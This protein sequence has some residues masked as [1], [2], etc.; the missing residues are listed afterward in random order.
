MAE[1]AKEVK[2]SL[3]GNL[4]YTEGQAHDAER[5]SKFLW[6]LG[7]LMREYGVVKADVCWDAPKMLAE[8]KE[9]AE[10]TPT[11]ESHGG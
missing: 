2:S 7:A 3:V 9:L 1:N 8:A 10:K 5:H 6:A 4:T 11:I